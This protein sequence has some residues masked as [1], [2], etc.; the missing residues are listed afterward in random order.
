MIST[1]SIDGTL[2]GNFFVADASAPVSAQTMYATVAA[3]GSG[4]TATVMIEYIH[5]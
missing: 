5:A 3:S 2:N 1:G 4:G